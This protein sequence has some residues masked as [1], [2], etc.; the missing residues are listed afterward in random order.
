MIPSPEAQ[1]RAHKTASQGGGGVN[2]TADGKGGVKWKVGELEW[3]A[4]MRVLDNAVSLD[5]LFSVS[6]CPFDG[7]VL[8]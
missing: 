1:A 4:W 2:R 7:N 3:E 5:R 8:L 6:V